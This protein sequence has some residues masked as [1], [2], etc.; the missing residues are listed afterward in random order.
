M[1]KDKK[2]TPA[3]LK[4]SLLEHLTELRKRLL[5]SALSLAVAFPVCWFFSGALLDFIRKPITPFLSNTAGGLIFT[6]P[7]DKFTAHLQTALFFAIL[8]SSPFWLNQ[9]WRFVSPGLYKKERKAFILF[10]LMGTVL[11]FA[12]SAFAYFL[13]FPLVFS[14]LLNF[15]GGPDR[16]FITIGNY[17]SFVARFT[18]TLGSVFELPLILIFLS[19]TGVV[20]VK[21][22]QNHRRHAVLGLAVL[23]AFVTPPDILSFFLLLVPLIALYESSIWLAGGFSKKL[24]TGPRAGHT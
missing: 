10:W 6:A 15:G 9:L 19:H 7:L 11:F 17:L 4:A 14:V 23:S 20:S 16:A 22:L 12:G 5:N 2:S 8:L 21:T 24:K 18:L 3:G 1:T 13:V